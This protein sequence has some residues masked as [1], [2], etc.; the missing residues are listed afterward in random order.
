MSLPLGLSPET[1]SDIQ[2]SL[3]Q[4]QISS[5]TL[6]ELSDQLTKEIAE[7]EAAINKLNLGIEADIE[8]ESRSSRDGVWS[9]GWKLGYGKESG[10][11]GFV[12]TYW[13]EDLNW[14]ESDTNERWSFKDSPR[15]QRVKS[16][17]K[18]PLLLQALVKQS[19]DFAS[20]ITRKVSLARGLASS[21]LPTKL[22]GSRK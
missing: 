13:T 22:D 5:K 8:I 16:V 21:V 20:D 11:W 18:I 15:E 4:L 9:H 10:K 14:P 6:N 1:I 2:L 19:N 12:I 7:I 3:K 17:E